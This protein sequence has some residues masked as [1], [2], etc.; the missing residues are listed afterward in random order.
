MESLRISLLMTGWLGLAAC[1]Q[2]SSVFWHVSKLPSLLRINDIALCDIP[3]F[4][5]PFLPGL[6][7]CKHG[8][9]NP[10]SRPCFLVCGLCTH[11]CYLLGHLG[12]MSKFLVSCH[13]VLQPHC[14]LTLPPVKC[15]IKAILHTCQHLL[16][17]QI[18]VGFFLNS[19]HPSGCD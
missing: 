6:G 18:V 16:L 17:P 19:R 14:H 10:S 4:T 15:G 11:K 12:V 5:F 1:S 2:N 8:N 9:I 13:T 3:H 7:Y